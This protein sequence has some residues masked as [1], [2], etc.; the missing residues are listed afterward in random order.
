MNLDRVAA[1]PHSTTSLVVNGRTY[2]AVNGR[3]HAD[4][5]AETIDVPESD[6]K[7]LVANG[8]AIVASGV[9][10]TPDPVANGPTWPSGVVGKPIPVT[11]DGRPVPRPTSPADGDEFYDSS[12]MATIVWDADRNAWRRLSKTGGAVG[13][14]V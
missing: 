4:A 6:S 13:P 12:L 2:S 5:G 3:I 10:S 8:W 14:A 9:G 7:V 1:P 11:A